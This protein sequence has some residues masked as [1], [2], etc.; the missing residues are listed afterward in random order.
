MLRLVAIAT[1]IGFGLIVVV[2][3]QAMG[4]DWF[5]PTAIALGGVYAIWYFVL[6]EPDDIED[7]PAIGS[8]TELNLPSTKPR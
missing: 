3:V 6:S 7:D 4:V 5:W 8:D 2:L 1:C